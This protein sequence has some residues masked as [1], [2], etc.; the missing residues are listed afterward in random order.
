MIATLVQDKMP[1]CVCKAGQINQQQ[2]I[3]NIITENVFEWE[4]RLC[5]RCFYWCG[6]C[7]QCKLPM[8]L[9]SNHN[10]CESDKKA[11]SQLCLSLLVFYFSLTMSV[12]NHSLI[13]R[14]KALIADLVSTLFTHLAVFCY[15]RT[16]AFDVK[17]W[18]KWHH[19]GVFVS[20]INTTHSQHQEEMP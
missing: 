9:F 18:C 6:Q 3:F 10:H 14:A 20:N 4:W 1:A 8:K 19:I 13:Y 12:I 15:H 16:T 17:R 2:P 11:V 5:Q 7:L